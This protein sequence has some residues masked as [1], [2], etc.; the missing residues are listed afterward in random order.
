[1]SQD[2]RTAREDRHVAIARQILDDLPPL[3]KEERVGLLASVLGV[4][5]C[6]IWPA[7]EPRPRN[8]LAL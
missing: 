2:E 1:M 6:A 5:A 3:S 7:I 8:C 4:S